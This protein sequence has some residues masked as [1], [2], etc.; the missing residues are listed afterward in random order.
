M[1]E[2]SEKDSHQNRENSCL[3]SLFILLLSKIVCLVN[4]VKSTK[5]IG[6][7]EDIVKNHYTCY[8]ACLSLPKY[9]I[10]VGN[11]MA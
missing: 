2:I 8:D 9:G 7:Y 3:A 5:M 11:A 6:T 4:N 10:L 1:K